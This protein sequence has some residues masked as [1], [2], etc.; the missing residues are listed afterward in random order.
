MYNTVK[1]CFQPLIKEQW[2][3]HQRF[4]DHYEVHP[5]IGNPTLSI[6]A[7]SDTDKKMVRKKDFD[8]ISKLLE[9][10]ILLYGVSHEFYLLSP[11]DLLCR[12]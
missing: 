3:T 8:V 2:S 10:S 11:R 7:F 4:P 6:M 1:G 12:A 5:L 9:N